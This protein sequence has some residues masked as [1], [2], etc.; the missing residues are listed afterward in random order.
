M[1]KKTINYIIEF[2]KEEYKFIIFM[3][4]LL[5]LLNYPVNYYITAGG[6]ISDVSSR[7]EVKD[8]YK[9]KGNF[10]LSYVTELKGT[11]FSYALSYIIPTWERLSADNYKY[12]EEESIEDIEFRSD[13][14]LKT[15]NGTATYWA[16]TL[17]NK[18]LQE[19]SSK[20]Y[21]ILIDNKEFKTDLKVQDEIL[22]I[23]GKTYKTTKEYK[24]YLQT[25]NTNDKVEVKVLRDNK[26]KVITSNIYDYKGT[27]LLG[28]GLQTVKE[29]KTT[30]KV[31]IKFKRSESGPSG[32]LITTLEIYNQLI[33]KDLTKGHII[34]GTGTIEEDGTVGQ[35]GGVEYKILGAEKGNA[36]YFLVPAGQNYK[37]AKKYKE[38][39]NLKIKLIKVK[40]IQDAIEKLEDLK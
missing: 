37:D 25:K 14:D 38:K 27:K 35:I 13:L 26:E 20:V 22:S 11:L 30:P 23:D 15:A 12:T 10:N 28:I 32:G 4:L 39:N 24:E 2:I 18:H 5:I 34:A 8:K 1:I 29:Y 31:D 19:T 33:K 6:G 40:S 21:V 3:L 7:I 36:E 9:S 16:Y 17:A